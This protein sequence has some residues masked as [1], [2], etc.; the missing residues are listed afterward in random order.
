MYYII[1]Y[2]LK[3]EYEFSAACHLSQHPRTLMVVCDWKQTSSEQ[4]MC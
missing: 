3:E 1:L 4:D 2:M